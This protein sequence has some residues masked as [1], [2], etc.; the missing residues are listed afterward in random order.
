V[1]ARS[2]SRLCSPNYRLTC[3]VHSRSVLG[4]WR[5]MARLSA[6]GVSVCLC[7]CVQRANVWCECDLCDRLLCSIHL[8]G[9]VAP[10]WWCMGRPMCSHA[11]G[12]LRRARVRRVRLRRSLHGRCT[13]TF[14]RSERKPSSWP[15]VRARAAGSMQWDHT[16]VTI[17]KSGLDAC[18]HGA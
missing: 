17:N 16:K 15:I 4:W 10:Q 13:P 6:V 2:L 5:R 3:V 11:V 12:R 1:S 18:V 8:H 7:A 14:G 9:C